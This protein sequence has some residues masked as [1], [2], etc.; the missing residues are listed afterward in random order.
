MQPFFNGSHQFE[1]F[2]EDR[3]TRENFLYGIHQVWNYN[4]KWKCKNET[5]LIVHM[6]SELSLNVYVVV[7]KKTFFIGKD[8]IRIITV[9]NETSPKISHQNYHLTWKCKKKSFSKLYF[10]SEL[11]LNKVVRK[12]NFCLKCTS[13]WNCHW[14]E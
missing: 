10:K 4:W 2:T 8:E 12:E 6:K 3:S 11:S 5:F 1:I 9:Q 7:Q 14:R 13:K